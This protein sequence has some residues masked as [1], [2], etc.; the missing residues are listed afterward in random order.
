MKIKS[1]I[2]ILTM[3]TLL[4]AC[5]PKDASTPIP[6]LAAVMTEV[7]ESIE[8][9]LESSEETSA[10]T[11]V[12]SAT[13]APNTSGTVFEVKIS[14]FAFEENTVT[15]KVGD[16]VT[17]TNHESATHTVA[18]DDGSF[19]SSNLKNDA[20]FSHTFDSA[21]TYPYHCGFHS[22]MTG[23]VIVVP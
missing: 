2:T 6:T 12:A 20:S 16:T 9:T 21:G 5:T 19:I 14:G 1:L 15:I 17:W 10:P 23:T 4:A 7:M 11:E 18:A 3:A 22:S 13:S 8:P